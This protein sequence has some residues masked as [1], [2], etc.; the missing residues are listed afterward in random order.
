MTQNNSTGSSRFWMWLHPRR[1][2]MIFFLALILLEAV[3][4]FSGLGFI[5]VG[6]F[7]I[8]VLHIPPILAAI[9]IGLPEG[10]S[11]A[12]IFGF[13]SMYNAYV[14]EGSPLDYLFKNPTVAVLPRLMI[15]IVA[16]TVL[17]LLRKI[18]DDHTLSAS[19]ITSSIAAVCGSITNTF[20]VLLSIILNYSDLFGF[21]KDFTARSVI[22]SNLIAMNV[23]FEIIAAA[24]VT[25]LSVLI[26]EKIRSRDASMIDFT[27]EP[28]R[29]TFQKWFV[30]FM[31]TTFFVVLVFM[32]RM[33]SQQDRENA[34]ILLSEKARDVSRQVDLSRDGARIPDLTLGKSGYVLLIEN[35]I[36]KKAGRGYFEERTTAEL[37]IDLDQLKLRKM[38][39]A[40]IDGNPGACTVYRSEDIFVLAFLPET[41]IYAERNHNATMLLAGLLIMF[42]AIHMS[43]SALVH[44]NVVRKIVDINDSLSQ[45]RSGNL[46]E[47]VEVTGNTEFAELSL[48]INTTV[49]ALKATMDE[50]QQRNHQEL[51]FA[52]EVQRSVL[53]RDEQAAVQDMPYE[54]HGD[55]MAARE[56]GGDF[57]DYF[58]IGEDKLGFVIADVSGKGIPAAL[59][60]MTAKTLVKNVMLN[61]KSPAEALDF[62]NQQLCTNNEKAMFVT[63]WLGILDLKRGILEFANAAHNPPLLKK[64]GKPSVYMDH[65]SYRRSLMLGA[66]EETVYYNNR[67]SFEPGDLLFLYTDGV[68]EATSREEKLYGEE[69][70]QKCLEENAALAPEKLIHA[71]HEDINRF[72]NGAEQFDDITMVVLRMKS[73][74]E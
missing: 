19:L 37:G 5:H 52:R 57:Y 28:I 38:F 17:R 3:L 42:V 12:A 27:P 50:I 26:A 9:I 53:P 35:G 74:K 49:D 36:V 63:V 60:M 20:F 66:M 43:I 24:V 40:S 21:T 72:V 59:L 18:A 10:L 64:A 70:L 62:A 25:V 48:G 45:I 16:W 39:F 44:N 4:L 69:R 68:T 6:K 29:K 7:S 65:K 73:E 23:M 34:E 47:K 58:L 30:L 61:S 67:I 11:L 46:N 41:E 51:E 14:Q 56:V 22:I 54:I 1:S 31:V 32:Y 15:P 2:R 33:L 71:V 8:T 13:L 55:M